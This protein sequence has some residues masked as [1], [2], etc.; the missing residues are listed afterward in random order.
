MR[1]HQRVVVPG[2]LPIRVTRDGNGPRLEGVATVIGVGG[3]FCRTKDTLAPGTVLPLALTC[4]SNSVAVECGVRH[5][6][7]NGMGIEF[8]GLT[9]ENEQKL[10]ELLLQLW[11]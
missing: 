11:A 6:N 9:P 8:T 2:A 5:V 7:E 10:K 4:G 1:R 3:M